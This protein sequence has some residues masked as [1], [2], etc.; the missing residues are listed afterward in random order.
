MELG[1]ATNATIAV[2]AELAPKIEA[3]LR[4]DGFL[5]QQAGAA[6]GAAEAAVLIAVSV[7]SI[8]SLCLLAEKLRRL[9]LPRTYIYLG[10]GEPDIRVDEGMPDGRIVVVGPNGVEQLLDEEISVAALQK[11][12]RASPPQDA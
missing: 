5:F 6:R 11:A 9:R 2:Q 7:S 4:E 10:P 8:V 1:E 12:L 3:A